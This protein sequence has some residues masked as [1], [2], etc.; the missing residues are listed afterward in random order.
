MKTDRRI[1][2]VLE[3]ESSRT[4]RQLGSLAFWRRVMERGLAPVQVLQASAN[5][6]D[7]PRRQ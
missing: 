3:V 1:V 5:K 4:V 7:R 2:V 6:V